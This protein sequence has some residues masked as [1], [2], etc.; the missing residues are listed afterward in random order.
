MA[1]IAIGGFLH[2]TNCFV[3]MR[4]DYDYY[5]KGG[6]FPPLAR[7]P[8]VIERTQGAAFGMSG[9]LGEIGASHELEPLI[10][11]HGG[12][13]GYITDDCFERIVGECQVHA[14]HFEQP[15]VLFDQRVF[16]L[17]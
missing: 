10:W 17:G 9:F 16:W 8:E 15:L 2:E 7:G 1:R 3:A 12:A 6:E 5:A 13:G 14:F 11:G 4:T